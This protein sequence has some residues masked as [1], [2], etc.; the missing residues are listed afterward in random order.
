MCFSIDVRL[1]RKLCD[2]HVR[3]TG[4][5]FNKI[6]SF[7]LARVRV[8]V[9]LDSDQFVAPGRSGK[10]DAVSNLAGQLKCR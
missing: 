7:L 3:P 9:E 5:N 10:Q 6:R 8:G 1:E 2:C 4:F